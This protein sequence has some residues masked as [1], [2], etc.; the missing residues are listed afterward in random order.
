MGSLLLGHMVFFYSIF[1]KSVFKI[2]L[3]DLELLEVILYNFSMIALLFSQ[4]NR[5]S[6]LQ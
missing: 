2:A 3:S 5:V 6:L 4:N 1:S